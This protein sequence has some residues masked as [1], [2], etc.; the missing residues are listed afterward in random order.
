MYSI[1]FLTALFF[2][3]LGAVIGSFLNVVLYRTVRQ[4][5]WLTG[6]SGCD[7]CGKPLAWFDNIPVVSY[8]LLRGHSRCCQ[9][10]LALT[11]PIVELL[12][13]SLFV[14]WYVIGVLFIFRL[15][16]HPYQILQPLFW[17]VV[18]VLLLGI[19]V[20]D[21]L[22]MIIPDVFVVALT[23]FSLLYR[24]ILVMTGS[25]QARDFLFSLASSIVATL[26]FFGLW[27]LTKRKGIGFG[28]VKFVFPM[29][30]L[31]GWPRI[32]VGIMSAFIAGAA[33]GIFVIIAQK[34]S[35]KTAVPFGPFLVFGTIFALLW[36]YPL[37]QWYF[38]LLL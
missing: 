37:A 17:L 10:T 28:D 11:H 6:R 3:L 5:Q 2:A 33:Y 16:D 35:L 26:L 30:L 29:G 27:V 8:F 7:Y 14:W 15:T 1:I 23:I 22:Y 25:M 18:G 21:S 12:S 31:L 34:K 32:L 38:N 4:K 20:A 36:G 9:K 13:A 19:L 24:L